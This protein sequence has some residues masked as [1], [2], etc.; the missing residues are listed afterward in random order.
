MGL[1]RT[2]RYGPIPRCTNDL[3][4]DMDWL[5]SAPVGKESLEI[6]SVDLEVLQL[7][8]T[9]P[10]ATSKKNYA[11]EWRH[12]CQEGGTCTRQ[13]AIRGD[14]TMYWRKGHVSKLSPPNAAQSPYRKVTP[15]QDITRLK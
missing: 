4:D 9:K 6:T 11:T 10:N 14:V 15:T 13:N 12:N 5:L 3:P 8:L 7:L 1:T 2:K